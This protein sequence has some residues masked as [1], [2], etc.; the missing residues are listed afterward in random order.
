MPE[1]NPL[2]VL[3]VDDTLLYRKIL[4]DVVNGLPGVKTIGT[5]NNGKIA[6]TR[7]KNLNPD[8]V[9]MDI[10][11]PEMNGIETL[12]YIKKKWPDIGVIMV[13][14]Y[15]SKD[16][17]Y[18]MKALEIGAF[19]FIA[20]PEADTMEKNLQF[21]KKSLY[22]MIKAYIRRSEIRNLLRK[23]PENKKALEKKVLPATK[24]ND[25][26]SRMKRLASNRRVKSNV[27]TIGI[28]TGGPN[29][30]AKVIPQLPGN[31]NV[32]IL[33]VQHMPPVF[34]Q[35]LA[36]SLD[37]KSKLTIVEATEGDIVKPNY[38][39]IA[40]GGKQMKVVTDMKGKDKII[41]IT[42]DPPENNCKPSA[43]YLFRS[44]AN[45]YGEKSTGVIMTG[46]GS[47]GSAGLKVLKAKGAFL[48][49]QNEK[50]CVVYGM[51]REPIE[52]GII[53]IISPLDQIADEIVKTV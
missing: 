44:V 21:I 25:L 18:T 34:T 28:S 9:I 42:D 53:D 38:V 14:A 2:K 29:A 15:N 35:A 45:V 19:D 13:S 1:A 51:P 5:A 50:S 12:E 36:Q 27:I 4:S 23:A 17:K 30:L 41:R 24:S 32:P 8:L 26:I 31:L 48:I 7:I 49:A 33:I 47:D 37:A 6:I 11:M 39:Y 43:D 40:P 22:P 20:K 16:S 3:V 10:H 52:S 46:M